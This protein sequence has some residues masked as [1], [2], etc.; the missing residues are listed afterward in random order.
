MRLSLHQVSGVIA[1]GALAWGVVRHGRASD[2][3]DERPEPPRRHAEGPVSSSPRGSTQSRYETIHVVVPS[4]K[5]YD[6]LRAD[7]ESIV[8]RAD[9]DILGELP[10]EEMER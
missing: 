6:R 7:F 9:F 2:N 1:L 5:P 3:Q 10:A 4:A 8:P